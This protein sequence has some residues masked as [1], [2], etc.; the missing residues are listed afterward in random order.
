MY[1]GSFVL[2]W[3]VLPFL[4]EY[5]ASG[6]FTT[7]EKIMRSIKNNVPM[8]VVYLVLFI[9]VV[10]ILSVTASGREALRK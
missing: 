4:M 3:V 5:L 2:N 1:W 9:V 8:L 7:R 6:D 10:I